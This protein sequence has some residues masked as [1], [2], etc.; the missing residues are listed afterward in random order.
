MKSLM[1]QINP[2]TQLMGLPLTELKLC[3]C[4]MQHAIDLK[5]SCAHEK[6]I[7]NLFNIIHI[8]L[9]FYTLNLQ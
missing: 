7:Y 1:H 8:G 9:V 5:F 3:H 6:T 4:A 2:L